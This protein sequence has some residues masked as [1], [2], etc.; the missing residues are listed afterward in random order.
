MRHEWTRRVFLSLMAAAGSAKSTVRVGCQ[1]RSYGQP[2]R[3][4]AGLL[5]LIVDMAGAGYQGFETNYVLL[6]SIEDAAAAKPQ[7]EK[8]LPL[9]GLHFGVLLHLPERE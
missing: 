2:P 1:T 8:R 9:I 3:T 5:P 4:L 6:N 7:I